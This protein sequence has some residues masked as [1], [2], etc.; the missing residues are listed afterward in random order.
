VGAIIGA[1]HEIASVI[2]GQAANGD[3]LKDRG[4]WS[5]R[6]QER[7]EDAERSFILPSL[8]PSGVRTSREVERPEVLGPASEVRV[9]L[10]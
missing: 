7:A 9:P 1:T 8:S 2:K 6:R 10:S 5:R 4:E 3:R